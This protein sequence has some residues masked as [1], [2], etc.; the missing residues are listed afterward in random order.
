MDLNISLYVNICNKFT[1]SKRKKS[2]LQYND[3]INRIADVDMSIT[4]E[5]RQ[6]LVCILIHL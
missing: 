2:K 5:N 4:F 6:N 1:C 3:D